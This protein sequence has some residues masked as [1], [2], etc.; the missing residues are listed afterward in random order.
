MSELKLEESHTIDG[1]IVIFTA[2]IANITVYS[3]V[4]DEDRETLYFVDGSK[5]VVKKLIIEADCS[6]KFFGQNIGFVSKVEFLD[7]KGK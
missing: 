5:T 1:N 2:K 3:D 7:F 4:K 6:I